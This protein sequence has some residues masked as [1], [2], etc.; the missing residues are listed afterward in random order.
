LAG[1]SNVECITKVN[2]PYI[3]NFN[4]QEGDL[5]T[6]STNKGYIMEQKIQKLL[7]SL[8]TEEE[9]LIAIQHNTTN[10]EVSRA[11]LES[12]KSVRNLIDEVNEI[13]RDL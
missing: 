1:R 4:E 10:D 13:K 9:R 6:P 2:E 3:N 12:V 5:P 8:Y 7:H 11:T